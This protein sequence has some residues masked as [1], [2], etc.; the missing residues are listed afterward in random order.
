MVIA[1]EATILKPYFTNKEGEEFLMYFD[2]SVLKERS[3]RLPPQGQQL[4][5]QL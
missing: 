1:Y 3:Y 2:H 4:L 5:A